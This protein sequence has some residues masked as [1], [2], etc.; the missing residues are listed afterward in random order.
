[1]IAA[2]RPRKIPKMIGYFPT[3]E[4]AKFILDLSEDTG[5]KSVT[6]LIDVLISNI[7]EKNY[8]LIQQLTAKT[9][10]N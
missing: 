10:I 2:K 3:P 8:D 5:I 7:K 6:N 9:T 4:N 1:M